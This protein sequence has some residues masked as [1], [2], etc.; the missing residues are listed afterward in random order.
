MVG[1]LWPRTNSQKALEYSASCIGE[2]LL[3]SVENGHEEVTRV[4]L[5]FY[6]SNKDEETQQGQNVLLLAIAGG[7]TSIVKLL[8]D[9]GK[10]E[11]ASRDSDGRTPLS[12]AA[13]K[14]V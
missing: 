10:V 5:S 1:Y 9:S 6:A 14:G 4:L 12:Q 13:S 3:L 2:A 7:F 11:P 8:L